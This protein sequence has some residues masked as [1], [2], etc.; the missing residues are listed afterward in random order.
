MDE[1]NIISKFTTALLSK[2]INFAIKQKGYDVKVKLNK[3]K[4]E[5]EEGKTK[6]H[7]DCDINLEGGEIVKIL[8]D[9]GCL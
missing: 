4:A 1:I 7:V 9:I 6:L 2:I 8:K 5:S 3:F